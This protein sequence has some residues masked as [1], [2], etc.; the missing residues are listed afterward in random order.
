MHRKIIYFHK[1]WRSDITR[2]TFLK[3]AAA[4]FF[5]GKFKL[6]YSNTED[7]ILH[8]YNIHSGEYALIRY[9]KDGKYDQAALRD[10]YYL[11]RCPYTEEI[12]E[13]DLKVI[14]LLC[15]IK[16]SFSRNEK[17]HIISGYRSKVYNDYLINAG[18]NVSKNSLHLYGKAIDFYLPSFSIRK[19]Y[20]RAK[21][22]KAG[23]VGKYKDFIHIDVGRLRYW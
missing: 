22:F 17:I 21:S 20:E 19:L 3:A 16:D 6:A 7:R 15:S 23:G 2:R 4:S 8:L 10:I 12:K 13:I 1:I 18:R 14:D 5:L 9:F 11:L